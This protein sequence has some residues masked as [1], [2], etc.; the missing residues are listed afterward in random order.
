MGTY[1]QTTRKLPDKSRGVQLGSTQRRVYNFGDAELIDKNNNQYKLVSKEYYAEL[2]R[3]DFFNTR[4][5]RC[6][7]YKLK[8]S[9]GKRFTN[10]PRVGS[11]ITFYEPFLQ[12]EVGTG[13]VREMYLKRNGRSTGVCVIDQWSWTANQKDFTRSDKYADPPR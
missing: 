3:K 12:N 1:I 7:D 9:S 11:L 2:I 4:S 13:Y 5:M 10:T 8:R 6:F